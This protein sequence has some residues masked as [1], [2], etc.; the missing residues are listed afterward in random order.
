MK[1]H[2]WLNLNAIVFMAIGISFFLYAPLMLN[3]FGIPESSGTTQIYWLSASFA[4]MFGAMLFG[5]GLLI[6]SIRNVI[7]NL[8]DRRG[9]IFTLILVNLLGLAVS[10]TQQVSVWG[11]PAGWLATGV[12]LA[13]AAGYMFLPT[14]E[15]S[16]K[17][18]SDEPGH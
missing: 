14:T 13:L 9:L 5:C 15:K 16:P 6:F 4:R 10:V 17:M 11:T 12:F 3:F 7:G 8:P 1:L 2:F 18:A